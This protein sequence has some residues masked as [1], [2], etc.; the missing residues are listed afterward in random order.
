[1]T[2]GLP[3]LIRC[4]D[5]PLSPASH[6]REFTVI[7]ENIFLQP[8]CSDGINTLDIQSAIVI[9]TRSIS[10]KYC[11]HPFTPWF[12]C[13]LSCIRLCIGQTHLDSTEYFLG[14]TSGPHSFNSVQ[15]SS[16]VMSDSLQHHGLQHAKPPCPS[17]TPGVYSI[18]C[19]FSWWCHPTTSSSV[20]PF[21]SHLQSF[22]ASWSFQWVSSSHQ[23]AKVLKL[24][25]LSL[26]K[27]PTSYVL[28]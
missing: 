11:E 5:T 19:P 1:M 16:S 28:V 4:D 26:K 8:S 7:T 20:I 6:L 14:V 10:A 13:C 17:S 9:T 22:P 23:V 18:S 27:Q 12:H 15:F 3:C 24:P 2:S 25:H 21:S